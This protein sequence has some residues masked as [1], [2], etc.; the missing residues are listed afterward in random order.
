MG[1]QP[2]QLTREQM[3]ER[4]I[5]GGKLLHKGQLPKAEIARELGVSRMAVSQWA[6]RIES[7]GMT[8]LSRRRALGRPAKLDKAKQ[9]KLKQI[10]LCGAQAA[11]FPTERWTLKRIRRVIDEQFGVKY[12]TGSVARLMNRIGLTPQQPQPRATERDEEL[13]RAW[14]SKDWNR[15]KK[16]AAARANNCVS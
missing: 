10:I 14:L 6:Q 16:S 4:R 2:K 12:H 11:G 8:G 15:I 9:E 3:E 1:W 7:Q 5:Q 13:I